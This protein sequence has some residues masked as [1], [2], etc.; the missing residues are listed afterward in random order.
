MSKVEKIAKELR[1]IENLLGQLGSVENP[2]L[3]TKEEVIKIRKREEV[4]TEQILKYISPM[5]DYLEKNK[6]KIRP[7]LYRKLIDD[8]WDGKVK[9][10][11]I[12]DDAIKQSSTD[13]KSK[14][15]FDFGTFYLFNNKKMFHQ[16]SKIA[17]LKK[18]V[19]ENAKV[20]NPI[21]LFV[22]S[23]KDKKPLLIKI[24][25]FTLNKD[26]KMSK[27]KG[28]KIINV[29]YTGDKSDVNEAFIL[30]KINSK[31][32]ESET[33]KESVKSEA[34]KSDEEEV[35]PVKKV[36]R[37]RKNPIPIEPKVKKPRGRPSA[38]P[39]EE[40][41][42]VNVLRSRG[43]PKKVIT[44]EEI[45]EKE[46]Q[47]KEK[48][49]KKEA[50]LKKNLRPYY[51]VGLVPKYHRRATMEEAVKNKQVMFWGINK[52]DPKLIAGKSK[53]FLKDLQDKR[54]DLM[55]KKAGRIANFNKIKKEIELA[56]LKGTPIKELVEKFEA[57]RQELIEMQNEM[58]TLE[59]EIKKMDKD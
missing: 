17:E 36:G 37:P 21:K 7:D 31:N 51:K 52:V 47:A 49:Q 30:D 8:T 56:K 38:K 55:V 25:Q 32:E 35:V 2:V 41:K 39:K 9:N 27:T 16:A 15:S 10:S 44:K 23:L 4:L 33:D 57:Q 58:K 20:K 12:I 48:Q 29:T 24:S 28:D 50:K 40:P 3:K 54:S 11:D 45:K 13:S 5:L 34:S 42:P 19:L 22:V 14:G 46:K 18:W 53:M 1:K 59:E 6:T 26:L 43:R